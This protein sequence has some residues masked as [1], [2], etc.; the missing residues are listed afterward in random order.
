MRLRTYNIRMRTTFQR[1]AV[2]GLVALG[3]AVSSADAP[4]EGRESHAAALSERSE[5]KGQEAQVPDS[6]KLEAMA[7]RFAPTEIRADLAHVSPAD[8]RVLGR[9][10][11]ASKIIDAI[12]LRQV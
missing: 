3:A 8:R 9:L 4:S 10:V 1:T 6:A 2:A 5:S 12:F 7:A 11:E